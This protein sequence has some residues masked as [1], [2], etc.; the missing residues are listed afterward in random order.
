MQTNYDKTVDFEENIVSFSPF[1]PFFSKQVY[2]SNS[3]PTP[4]L[5]RR[6]GRTAIKIYSVWSEMKS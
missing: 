2:Q 4:F 3:S 1:P 5:V 6:Q